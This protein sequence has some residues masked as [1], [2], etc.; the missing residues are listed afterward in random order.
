MVV[1]L[2]AV[3]GK[4]HL[5]MRAVVLSPGGAVVRIE[6]KQELTGRVFKCHLEPG[7]SRSRTPLES[8]GTGELGGFLWA[9]KEEQG[10][11][12]LTGRWTK[13]RDFFLKAP[14][15]DPLYMCWDQSGAWP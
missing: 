14:R 2:P 12:K 10:L 8:F 4:S 3:S 1:I 13:K 9:E 15:R 5:Q 11:P 7:P 6:F